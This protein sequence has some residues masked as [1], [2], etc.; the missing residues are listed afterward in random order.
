MFR[1]VLY[2]TQLLLL[3]A[4]R[5][6][7]KQVGN[8]TATVYNSTRNN[9]QFK[10]I[11]IQTFDEK[12][13]ERGFREDT[14]FNV[15]GT[16]KTKQ[17]HIQ[18]VTCLPRYA[19]SPMLCC[20]RFTSP[21]LHDTRCAMCL[22]SFAPTDFD[23]QQCRVSLENRGSSVSVF[24]LL[25]SSCTGFQASRMAWLGW[26]RDKRLATGHHPILLSISHCAYRDMLLA[27]GVLL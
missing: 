11:S 7:R 14:C 17:Y 20:V 24:R 2:G 22:L 4:V 9:E 16:G 25:Y 6:K 21:A 18:Y 19:L 1:T 3:Q 23:T 12:K 8:T 26:Y 5:R 10:L 15:P 27:T 13:E